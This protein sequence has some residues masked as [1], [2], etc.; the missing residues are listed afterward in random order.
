MKNTQE[1]LA[2]L[3][4]NMALIG[5]LNKDNFSQKKEKGKQKPAEKKTAKEKKNLKVWKLKNRN[6]I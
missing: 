4:K 2:V 5:T 3:N 1:A 6:K